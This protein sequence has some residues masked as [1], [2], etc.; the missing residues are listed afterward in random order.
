MYGSLHG[1]FCFSHWTSIIYLN[2]ILFMKF[3]SVNISGYA[4]ISRLS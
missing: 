4:H 3:S 2:L 1:F